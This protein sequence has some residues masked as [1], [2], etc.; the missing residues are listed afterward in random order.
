MSVEV[1]FTER[2]E[3][4]LGEVPL[5]FPYAKARFLF[6]ALAERRDGVERKKLCRLIWGEDSEPARQSLRNALA[7]LRR[8]LP[9]GCVVADRQSVRLD[10]VVKNAP[11]VPV[12]L[13]DAV[14]ELPP[15]TDDESHLLDCVAVF[16][17]EAPFDALKAVSGLDDMTLIRL[18]EK[19]RRKEILT[20]RSSPDPPSVLFRNLPDKQWVYENM[21]G[22]KRQNLYRRLIEYLKNGNEE[23]GF[24]PLSF[25]PSS[26]APPISAPPIS[27]LPISALPGSTL[28]DI[29]LLANRAGDP[30]T[31][32]GARIE[33]LRRHFEF[34]HELFPML[35]DADLLEA[36][37]EAESPPAQ[38]L[39]QMLGEARELLDRLVRRLGRTSRFIAYERE[40]L[41]LQGG[42][43]RWDGNYA[44]A[45]NCLEEALSL[46]MPTVGREK[47]LLEV[48]EQFCCLGIQKDSPEILRRYAFLFYRGAMK[49]QLHPQIGMALRFLAIL[50]IMEGRYEAASK[51][52]GMSVRMFEKLEAC[53]NGHTLG[54]VAATHYYG[55]IALFLGQHE[56]AGR[57]YRQCAK[58]CEGKG[59]YRGLGLYLAKGA[60]CA[61]RTG[62]LEAAREALSLA[63][64]LFNGFQSRRGAGMCAGEIAFGLCALLNLWDGEQRKALE[65][66]RYSEELS[67]ILQ[68]PLWNAIHFCIKAILKE[69]GHP[70]LEQELPCE[71]GHYLRHAQKLFESL[72]LPEEASNTFTQLKSLR[73]YK[74]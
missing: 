5:F 35:S 46:A 68:K 64:P 29:P 28:L 7:V 21:S 2:G 10:A 16:P 18:Y 25:A 52:L 70:M 20:E 30:I 11:L 40:L 59:F 36:S 60:W 74:A 37:R 50:G 53:G 13:D 34:H 32:L 3:A 12:V 33:V 51:L 65:N 17:D 27:A 49:A 54:V 39:T 14:W 73:A 38:K 8:I 9:E 43:L 24:A 15:L 67:G 41:T 48:L 42:F 6:L 23:M 31:E 22:L 1:S 66:L 55:D 61:L 57:Y 19:L 45:V 69:Y 47:A 62:D 56:E 44:D 72:R 4:Y 63:R 26:S 58:L 71:T